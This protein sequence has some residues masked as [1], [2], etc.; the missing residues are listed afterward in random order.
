MKP[1]PTPT[2]LAV[3]GVQSDMNVAGLSA[4]SSVV[5]NQMH[6]SPGFP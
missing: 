1:E 4:F 5:E 6:C 3:D 2:L